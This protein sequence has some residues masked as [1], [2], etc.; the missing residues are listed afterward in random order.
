MDTQMLRKSNLNSVKLI[1]SVLMGV[2]IAGELVSFFVFHQSFHL[3]VIIGIL[4][5]VLLIYGRRKVD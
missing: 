4:C 3:P 5:G 1:V 2:M